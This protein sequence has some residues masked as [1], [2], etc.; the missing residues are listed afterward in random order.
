MRTDMHNAANCPTCQATALTRNNYFTGKLM[1]ERDF[2]D[3]QRYFRERLR[4][5]NQRLHGSGVVCGLGVKQH[6]NPACQDRFVLLEP[7]SAIDCCGDDILVIAEDTVDLQSF[8]A[9][10]ALYDHPDGKDHVLQLAICYRE[11]PTEEI[12][13]LYD[14]CACDDSQCA[15]NRILESYSLD[16]IVDPVIAPPTI[17]IPELVNHGAIGVATARAVAVNE[18]GGSVFVLSEDTVYEIDPLSYGVK[19]SSSLMRTSQT[20]AIT[21][22]GKRLFVFVAPVSSGQDGE[23]WFFKTADISAGPEDKGTV[24]GSGAQVPWLAMSSKPMLLAAYPD[25][26]LFAWKPGD[27]AEKLTPTVTLSP[28]VTNIVA[29]TDGKMAWTAR[30]TDVLD[31]LDLTASAI[32]VA[33]YNVPGAVMSVLAVLPSTLPDKLAGADGLKIHIIDPTKPTGSPALRTAQLVTPPRAM[34]G[35]PDG[36]WVYVEE[37]DDEIEVIDVGRLLQNLPVTPSARFPVGPNTEGLAITASGLRLY[38]P[39]AGAALDGSDAGVAVFDVIDADCAAPLHQVHACPDCGAADCLVLATIKGYQPGY[40]FLDKVDPAP[41]D[42]AVKHIARIDELADRKILAS[43]EILQEVLECLLAHP[44]G[45]GTAG[46]QGPVGPQGPNGDPGD[47]GEDGLPGPGLSEDVTRINALSWKHGELA[48][49]IVM[50]EMAD[51]KTKEPGIVIGFS[52]KVHLSAANPTPLQFK[53]N[54]RN[55]LQVE[56]LHNPPDTDG[57]TYACT[58]RL[59]GEVVPVKFKTKPGDPELI[60]AAGEDK[61]PAE[62]IAFLIPERV[63]NANQIELWVRLLGEFVLDKNENAVAADFVGAKLPSGDIRMKPTDPKVAIPGGQF[64]SWFTLQLDNK[65]DFKKLNP[66]RLKG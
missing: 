61:F 30:G 55:I 2:T 31:A 39:Y 1:V 64:E 21:P 62:G 24:K 27:A 56:A 38:V 51:G 22:D 35:A 44:G 40:K 13:V 15:P 33:S 53:R 34:V 28:G 48:S 5:H 46:A 58:C 29:S 18:A 26:Q 49:S 65:N 9:V 16:V 12:P 54:K 66:K 45:G 36:N 8:P 41:A 57:D 3:E 47:D 25:G 32:A 37:T 20:M 7:G 23:V 50:V 42:D 60:I 43:T 63:F 6:P 52:E 59:N 11:C 19:S 10:K 4:L 17:G 14:D